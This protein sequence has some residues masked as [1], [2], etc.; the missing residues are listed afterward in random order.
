MG[1]G[2]PSEDVTDIADSE[3]KLG[4]KYNAVVSSISSL[5][6]LVHNRHWKRW[7]DR[8][9]CSRANASAA[10]TIVIA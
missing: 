9:N 5:S 7:F 8:R 1:E 6:G 10:N 3:D 4:D 2:P